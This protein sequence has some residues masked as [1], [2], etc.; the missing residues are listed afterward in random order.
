MKLIGAVCAVGFF[1]LIVPESTTRSQSGPPA[2]NTNSSQAV[3]G[4]Q[5]QNDRIKPG[6]MSAS[7]KERV[8]QMFSQCLKDWD[9]KTHMTKREWTRVCRRVVD[10]RANY[11]KNEGKDLSI[12]NR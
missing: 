2:K 4:S 7:E 8:D 6:R 9:A 10:N 5:T 1:A 3:P 12:I 11:L